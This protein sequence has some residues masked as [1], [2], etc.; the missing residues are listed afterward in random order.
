MSGRWTSLAHAVSGL[1]G[2]AY[3]LCWGVSFYPQLVINCRRQSVTGLALDFFAINV[4]GFACY[5][6]SAVLFLFSPVVRD[7][8]AARHPNAP[9]PTVRWNDLAFAVSTCDFSLR[10]LALLR[11]CACWP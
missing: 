2:W 4:L 3:F 1:L 9:E 10:A 11:S 5:T 8:Y 7:E 6:V